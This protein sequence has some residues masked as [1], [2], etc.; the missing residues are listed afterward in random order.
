MVRQSSKVNGEQQRFPG[1]LTPAAQPVQQLQAKRTQPCKGM[2]ILT[3]RWLQAVE[4]LK[5]SR[6]KYIFSPLKLGLH[7]KAYRSKGLSRIKG[8]V[9]RK[10][11]S[12][13]KTNLSILY[14]T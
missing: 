7:N 2:G 10:K 11:F 3:A 13:Y 4:D 12:V 1:F 5:G 8:Q 9:R 14:V 6:P